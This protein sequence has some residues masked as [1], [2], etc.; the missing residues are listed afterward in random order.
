MCRRVALATCQS[1]GI[2][3]IGGDGRIS[4]F[5]AVGRIVRLQVPPVTLLHPEAAALG[6]PAARMDQSVAVINIIEL[7]CDS[8]D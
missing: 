6:I 8:V 1:P 7:F 3:L 4:S 2:P 5:G